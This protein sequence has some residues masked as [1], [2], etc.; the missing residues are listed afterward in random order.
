MS[1]NSSWVPNEDP[2]T[3]FSERS[4]LQGVVIS[5]VA[6]GITVALYFLSFYLL[7]REKNRVEFK[8]RLPLLIYITISFLLGTLFMCALAAFTQMAFID[9]RN[10]PGGPNAY[11]NNEFSIPVDN[12]GNAA[13]VLS[14]WLSDALVVWRFKVIYQRCRV[15]IWIVMI[16]PCLMLAGSVAL[17]IGFLIQVSTTNPYVTNGVN[18]TLPYLSLSLALNILLTIAIV[19]RL[20][21]FRYR[22]VAVLGPKYGTHYTSI[23]AM[24]IESAALYS[25]V[26]VTFLVLF[27]IGNAVSQVFLQSLNQFQ[28]IATLLIVF[29]VAQG[30]GWTEE[31]ATYVMTSRRS[32]SSEFGKMRFASPGASLTLASSGEVVKHTSVDYQERSPIPISNNFPV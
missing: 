17:G 26:S 12:S 29:R 6:Y 13:F 4:W 14:N 11:E 2:Q 27:G 20:L 10:Y 18:F 9:D 19:L 30:K 21:T 23:A 8:K 3:L 1:S 16:L 5:A 24:I 15:P 25:A 22:T 7:V 32:E 31:T 28:T